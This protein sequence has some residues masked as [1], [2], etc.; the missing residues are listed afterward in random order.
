MAADPVRA[1]L[2]AVLAADDAMGVLARETRARLVNV[3]TSG[4]LLE[5]EAFLEPGTTGTLR[6]TVGRGAYSDAVRVVRAQPLRG[7]RSA[8]QI[9]VEFLWTSRPGS[10]SLRGMVSRLRREIAQQQIAVSFSSV[11]PN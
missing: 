11:G 6:V 8:W 5:S 7:A 4:C 2:E 3:S 10:W 1:R 9:G